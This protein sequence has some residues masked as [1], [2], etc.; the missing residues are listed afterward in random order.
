[1]R[2]EKLYMLPLALLLLIITMNVVNVAVTNRRISVWHVN[3][4]LPLILFN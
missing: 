4:I 2:N 3:F 1:M